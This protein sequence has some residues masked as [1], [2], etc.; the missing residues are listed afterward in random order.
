MLLSS[1]MMLRHLGLDTQAD[2]IAGVSCL[3]EIALDD[4]RDAASDVCIAPSLCLVSHVPL[5]SPSQAVY[6]VIEERKVR[7]ADVGGNSTTSDFTKA[8]LEKL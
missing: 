1:T 8:V 3:T 2:A 4:A 7:T 6:K 5:I